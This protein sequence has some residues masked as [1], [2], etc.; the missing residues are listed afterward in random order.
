MNRLRRFAFVLAA[1]SGSVLFV[2]CPDNPV[3][4]EPA[5]PDAGARDLG[6]RPPTSPERPPQDRLPDDLRPPV[7]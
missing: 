7:Q 1:L 6:L 3:D 4:P 2:G 5:A